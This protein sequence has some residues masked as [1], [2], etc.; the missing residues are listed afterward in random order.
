MV[1]FTEKERDIFSALVSN[2]NFYFFMFC[3]FFP[4]PTYIDLAPSI[5]VEKTQILTIEA[6]F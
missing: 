3:Y 2:V 4:P 1:E 5:W 6:C